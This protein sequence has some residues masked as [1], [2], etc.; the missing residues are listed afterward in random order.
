MDVRIL[1]TLE[2]FAGGRQLLLGGTKQRATL[3]VLVL[4]ANEVVSR[5]RLIDA[6]WGERQPATIRTVLQGY[7]SKL[8]KELPP[9]TLLTQAPGYLLRLTQN[10]LD[11]QR[12]ER[13]VAEADGADPA[14]A[15]ATLRTALSLWRGPALADVADEPFARATITRLEEL[16]LAALEARIESDL[17]LGRHGLLVGELEGLVLQHPFRE[18]LRG[19][20]MLALYRSGRQVEALASYRET[21]RALVEGLGIEPSP[22]LQQLETS[23]LRQD[24]ALAPRPPAVTR[25]IL[26]APRDE[27]ALD[28]LIALVEPLA[29]AEPQRE[30]IIARLAPPPELERT[31]ILVNERRSALLARGIAARAAVF[32]SPAPGE[33]LVELATE[34]NVDLLLIEGTPELLAD[35][36]ARSVLE[37]AP[38][39]V[40]VYVAR[41]TQRKLGPV[42]VPFGGADHD[43]A[44]LELGAWIA[45]ANEMP[46]ALAGVAA[47][48]GQGGRDAS[49]LLARASLLVQRMLGIAAE[50]VLVAPGADGL[51]EVAKEMGLVVVGLS[52]RWRQEGLGAVRLAVAERASPPTLLV[53]NGVRPGGLAPPE[54]YTHYTWTLAQMSG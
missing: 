19:Q 18:R 50:L 11:L 28:V 10:Q 52:P 6:V 36:V 48:L 39:D 47:D 12:F 41:E 14:E 53:R 34:Q 43:W 37:R 27:R 33:D 3:A 38:C 20:L 35:D 24:P 30:L 17:A 22:S 25:S 31:S 44:A 51:I 4:H 54:T 21:R 26:V 9:G 40:A 23:M 46:L 29:R 15:A 13:L 5:D 16:R 32:T 49:R 1:G 7:I 2:V 42:C 8:R 45:K